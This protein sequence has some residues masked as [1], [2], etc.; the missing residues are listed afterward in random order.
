M[1]KEIETLENRIAEIAQSFARQVISVMSTATMDE[2]LR[3]GAAA[4]NGHLPLARPSLIPGPRR[5]RNWPTC[6]EPGCSGRYYPASGTARLCYQ[7]FI[8]SGGR[9]PSRK[10]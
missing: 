3:V 8:A 9:H 1:A 7:H 5:R 2:L 6:I 10:K 4:R